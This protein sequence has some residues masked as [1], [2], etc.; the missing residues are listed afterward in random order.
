MPKFTQEQ[1]SEANKKAVCLIYAYLNGVSISC[2][3][4]KEDLNQILILAPVNIS[5]SIS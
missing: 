2:E 1:L 5:V 3:T 4:L